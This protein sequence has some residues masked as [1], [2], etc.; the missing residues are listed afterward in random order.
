[1]RRTSRKRPVDPKCGKRRCPTEAAAIEGLKSARHR[2]A[3]SEHVEDRV[4]PCPICHGWHLTSR[5][6]HPIPSEQPTEGARR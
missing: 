5:P 3:G 4:Y 6:S 2:H 1:M